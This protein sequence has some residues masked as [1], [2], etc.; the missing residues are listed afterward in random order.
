MILRKT[1]L[2]KFSE[3]L[4]QHRKCVA[5]HAIGSFDPDKEDG[6]DIYS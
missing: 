6:K 1:D 2:F 3:L 4:V 5:L